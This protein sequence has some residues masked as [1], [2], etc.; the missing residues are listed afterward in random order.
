MYHR[1][2]MGA[3]RSIVHIDC[4]YIDC[5]W[6]RP[7]FTKCYSILSEAGGI[8]VSPQ[9]GPRN[10]SLKPGCPMRPFFGVEPVLTNEKVTVTHICNYDFKRPLLPT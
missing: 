1:G 8:A 10:G 6:H 7:K 9:P 3:D 4:C 2:H 5:N